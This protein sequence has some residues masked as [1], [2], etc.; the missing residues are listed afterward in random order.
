[1]TQLQVKL[2]ADALHG[3]SI[4]KGGKGISGNPQCGGQVEALMKKSHQGASAAVEDF[5][6]YIFIKI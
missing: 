6:K 5:L 4:S 2:R 1:M 3:G